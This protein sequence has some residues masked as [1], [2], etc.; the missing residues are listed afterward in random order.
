M[1]F[2]PRLEPQETITLTIAE[3]VPEN[4][5]PLIRV[6]L[7]TITEVSS[8][9]DNSQCILRCQILANLWTVS[10]YRLLRDRLDK[11]TKLVGGSSFLVIRY[12]DYD[13]KNGT[14]NLIDTSGRVI[15]NRSWKKS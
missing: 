13:P 4:V 15:A 8:S 9:V 14:K 10:D 3:F 5:P 12:R 2:T 11:I 7:W 6:C 1:D